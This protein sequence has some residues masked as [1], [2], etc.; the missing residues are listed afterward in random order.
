[1]LI[2][3][4]PIKVY[5]T[6]NEGTKKMSFK[7]KNRKRHSRGPHGRALDNSYI[8]KNQ[9]QKQQTLPGPASY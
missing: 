9:E 2:Y 3:F 1:M 7:S 6:T 5:K 8:L 4:P